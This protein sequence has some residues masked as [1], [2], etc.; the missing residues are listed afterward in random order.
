[1]VDKLQIFRKTFDFVVWTMNHTQKFPKSYRFSIAVRIENLLLDIL[2][3]I[4]SAN[5]KKN[6]LPVLQEIDEKLQILRILFR[7]SNS[8]GF[9]QLIRM[10]MPFARLMKSA[11]FWV[12]GYA[13]RHL[14]LKKG[15]GHNGAN[16][17]LRGG[18]WNNES[19]NCRSANRNRN[20]PTNRNTN[21]GFRVASST[22]SECILT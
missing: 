22:V 1:M 3:R 10:N 13:N 8:S 18:S 19:N 16:R 11:S 6:K 5:V 20:E 17:V 2:E 4:I 15:M 7:L 21:N 9:F 12:A 14:S